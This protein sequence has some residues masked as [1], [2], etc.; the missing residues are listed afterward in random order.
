MHRPQA[1]LTASE[2]M[3]VEGGEQKVGTTKMVKVEHKLTLRDMARDVV[4]IFREQPEAKKPKH[5]DFLEVMAC[6]HIKAAMLEHKRFGEHMGADDYD[7][8]L[9]LCVEHLMM[10]DCPAEETIQL[11]VTVQGAMFVETNH[12]KRDAEA[13]RARLKAILDEIVNTKVRDTRKRLETADKLYF[14]VVDYMLEASRQ[15]DDVAELDPQTEAEIYAALESIFQKAGCLNFME[16]PELEKIQNIEEIFQIIPGIRCYNKNLGRGGQVTEYIF[17]LF[18]HETEE[19]ATQVADT[20]RDLHE[21]LDDYITSLD[22]QRGDL[23]MNHVL[24]IRLRDEMAYHLQAAAL[25]ETLDSMIN[26]RYEK[27]NGLWG[28]CQQHLSHLPATIGTLK[29]VPNEMVYPDFIAIGRIHAQISEER[30]VLHAHARAAAHLLSMTNRPPFVLTPTTWKKLMLRIKNYE[31]IPNKVE[32]R[33]QPANDVLEAPLPKKAIRIKEAQVQDVLL[34]G[35]ELKFAGYCP[36]TLSTTDGLLLH[37]NPDMGLIQV[38]DVLVACYDL[39][40]FFGFETDFA[41]Y[42]NEAF[43][44][45][46]RM[47]QLVHILGLQATPPFTELSIPAILQTLME[48]LPSEFGTQTDVHMYEEH[49]WDEETLHLR[50][51]QLS[52]KLTHSTQT[53]VSHFRRKNDTQV[54]LPKEKWTQGA[55]SRGTSMF[56]R[57]RFMQNLIRQ[58]KQKF[59]MVNVTYELGDTPKLSLCKGLSSYT[60]KGTRPAGPQR[61]GQAFSFKHGHY[62]HWYQPVF[63][64]VKEHRPSNAF[65]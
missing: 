18:E 63:H 37:G 41:K 34:R 15:Q 39:D 10:R 24:I 5:R 55:K 60:K 19:L 29:I 23:G 58:P 3:G 61:S 16:L 4:R 47:P 40:A 7:V 28:D 43:K 22:L 57:V 56:R 1:V 30:K 35:L 20:L 9:A 26:E 13:R 31:F 65:F 52:T 6:F 59:Y 62:P 50:K 54:W 64:P 49:R 46:K 44:L 32:F 27:V 42:M 45:V 51:L 25:L 8:L 14:L 11:Q 2:M 17:D 48:P 36:V 21:R 33:D 12:M 53:D 38:D